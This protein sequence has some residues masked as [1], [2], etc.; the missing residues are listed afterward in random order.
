[1]LPKMRALL[2]IAAAAVAA[3]S[4][5]SIISGVNV[6]KAEVKS[7][8]RSGFIEYQGWCVCSTDPSY[9]VYQDAVNNCNSVG[10]FA[11]SIHNANDLEFWRN[12]VTTIT[13]TQRHFWLDA[14]CP[15]SGQKYVWRDGTPTDYLGPSGELL[16]CKTNAGYHIHPEGFE[17]YDYTTPAPAL[18][19]YPANQIPTTVELTTFETTTPEA[20]DPTADYCTCEVSSIYLD[21]VF[22]VDVSA[23]MTSKT[24]GDVTAT[25][26]STLAGLTFGTGYFQS[27]VAIVSFADKVQTIVK[28]G[29]LKTTNDI[30]SF[31]IPYLGGKATKM[32]DAIKQ[33]SAL[34]ST[35]SRSFTRG[36]IVLFSKSFNQ[37][38]AVNINEAAE[39]FKDD[40]GI[41]MS[42][43][44]AKGQ[45]IR[46]LE[47]LAS[48]GFYINQGQSADTF[49]S[50]ILYAFCDANCFCPDGL[51]PF[52]VPN[53]KGRELPM[54]CF[55]I[56]DVAAVYSAAEQNCLNQKGFVATVHNDEKNFFLISIFPPKARYWIGL[57]NNGQRFEW[58][59]GSHEGFAY[60]APNQPVAGQD[61][62][63]EQQ[64]KGYTTLG[65]SAPCAD[66][67]KNSMTYA[68]QL[69]PCDSEYDCWS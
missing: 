7:T 28:F 63:Y 25:I 23:D 64:Q 14:Y 1:G 33:A 15:S 38:D 68:C 6:S 29:S 55:H 60:W 50:D 40:A 69:R 19:A 46:G 18:C 9:Y 54:G 48:P 42:M 16:N 8:C 37:L 13:P 32:A 30:W 53:E 41:F 35:N 43:D 4:A 26:Q 62:V 12:A 17:A 22:V 47:N 65:F 49:N 57:K 34:I 67:L 52:N 10:A 24:V 27:N 51:Y 21:I 36:V 45:G 44:Y 2:L 3:L 31:N 59:D 20:I 39:A 66:P 5:P 58:A 61:C 56:A 11:P